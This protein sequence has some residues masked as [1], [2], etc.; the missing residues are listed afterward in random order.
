VTRHS[1]VPIRKTA[2]RQP[3]TREPAAC[4]ATG[5]RPICPRSLFM[6]L[7]K[8]QGNGSHR[9]CFAPSVWVES[10]SQSSRESRCEIGVSAPTQARKHLPATNGYTCPAGNY[11]EPFRYYLSAATYYRAGRLPS[12]YQNTKLSRCRGTALALRGL[13]DCGLAD[14]AQADATFF[15]PPVRD[16][17]GSVSMVNCQTSMPNHY[18]ARLAKEVSPAGHNGDTTTPAA[19]VRGGYLGAHSSWRPSQTHARPPERSV[20]DRKWQAW[21]WA[22]RRWREAALGGRGASL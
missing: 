17:G 19:A 22:A 4:I 6:E 9:L 1:V 18:G 10:G 5:G 13:V 11:H 7:L 14:L 2:R 3:T 21:T 8:M 12:W 15:E 20:A 16:A